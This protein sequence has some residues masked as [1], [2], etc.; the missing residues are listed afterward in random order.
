MRPNF[1]G[2]IPN[3]LH[4]MSP[5]GPGYFVWVPASTSG[6]GSVPGTVMDAPT[7]QRYA[8]APLPV[9]A[10]AYPYPIAGVAGGGM[11]P[12][13]HDPASTTQQ[14]LAQQQQQ[15]DALTWQLQQQRVEQL[16]RQL[17]VGAVQPP[18][19]ASEA[20]YPP[21]LPAGRLIPPQ[22]PLPPPP[23]PPAAMPLHNEPALP[24]DPLAQPL[25]P[26]RE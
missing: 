15:I 12:P 9:P 25:P 1:G 3:P 6:L 20:L 17:Y 10:G 23:P 2:S 26:A 7:A 22:P 11:W 19:H 4:G 14:A 21:Q 24:T 8:T 13:P 18:T 5:P 16:Q